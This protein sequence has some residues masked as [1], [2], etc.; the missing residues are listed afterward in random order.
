MSKVIS[1]QLE[2]T[3][4][5]LI[6]QGCQIRDVKQGP[7]RPV[8]AIEGPCPLMQRMALT[9]IENINGHRAIA[10]TVNVG[11]CL[12]HWHSRSN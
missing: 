8:I 12:V 5:W 3:R 6:Q 2:R 10:F 9:I 11:G 1:F 4:H 7:K